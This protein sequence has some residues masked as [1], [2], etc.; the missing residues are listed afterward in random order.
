MAA[1]GGAEITITGCH[2]A[3]YVTIEAGPGAT[4]ELA[5]DYVGAGR[6]VIAVTS[7]V[8]GPGTQ[9][10]EMAVV[11]D[12]DHDHSRALAEMLF[13]SDKVAIGRDVWVGSGARIIR[14]VTMG[15]VASV[16]AG[17]VVTKDVARV[18]SSEHRPPAAYVAASGR[19][20]EDGGRLGRDDPQL[21]LCPIVT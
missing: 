12:A 8:I 19:R 14:G 2:L 18:A 15:D 1:L 13:V 6:F 5:A 3:R 17:A 9:L 11:G 16:G 4:I 7:I 20:H 10:G 21:Q